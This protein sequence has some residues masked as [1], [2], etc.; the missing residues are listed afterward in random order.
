MH[1]VFMKTKIASIMF[2]TLLHTAGEIPSSFYFIYCGGNFVLAGVAF[3]NGRGTLCDLNKK[4]L[5]W[6][7]IVSQWLGHNSC[8]SSKP[9]KSIGNQSRCMETLKG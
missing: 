5:Q 6:F 9:Q 8:H 3:G 2:R 7:H 4:L 1:F